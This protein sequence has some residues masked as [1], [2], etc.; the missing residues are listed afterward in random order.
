M[1]RFDAIVLGAGISGMTAA[2]VL[3]ERGAQRVLLVDEYGHLGGNH[4]SL[5]IGPFTYDIGSFIFHDNS[6]LMRR[7]PELRDLYLPFDGQTG[8]L[9]FDGRLAQYPF[10]MRKDLLQVGPIELGRMLGSLVH[11][12][13]TCDPTRSAQDFVSYWLG[14]RLA[15]RTGLFSY[16]ERFY[17]AS[18]ALIEG[19][20]AR[21]RMQWVSA[22]ASIR[23]QLKRLM[24]PRRLSNRAVVRPRG[25]FTELYEPVRASLGASGVQL[26][27]GERIASLE[28][29]KAGGLV[30]ST[31]AARYTAPAVYSTV[32]LDVAAQ[33]C[34]LPPNPSVRYATLTSLFYSFRGTRTFP[35]HVLYNFSN[36][37]RWKR[38]TM[39]S[40]CYGQADGREY[41]SVEIISDAQPDN[42][43]LLDADFRTHVRQNGFLRGDLVLEGTR[44]TASAY[45]IYLLGATAAAAGMITS[46]R[47]LG[48][49]SFGRQ[50]GFDYQPTS[51]VSSVMAERAVMAFGN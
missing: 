12:R 14:E 13:L 40:D 26:R 32:P 1:E 5:D 30:L 27:L 49:L 35:H 44:K 15:R 10:D 19:E 20:F 46:L 21:K 50:G 4:V 36:A 48:V 29:G 38:L 51:H 25:G 28:P 31:G 23:G 37:G 43:D 34:R 9:D 11:G 41:F 22:N 7:F 47:A 42:A 3:R 33:W 16:L 6:P 2:S 45:P 24:K 17:G 39:H 18:P 8:R